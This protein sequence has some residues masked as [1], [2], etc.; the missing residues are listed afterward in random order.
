M[1]PKV[2]GFSHT[3]FTGGKKTGFLADALGRF[4]LQR[5]GVKLGVEA[6]ITDDAAKTVKN[7]GDMD[8]LGEALFL[9]QVRRWAEGRT[10]GPQVRFSPQVPVVE[11]EPYPRHLY[12][13][14]DLVSNALLRKET[15][16]LSATQALNEELGSEKSGFSSEYRAKAS[17][18]LSKLLNPDLS[19]YELEGLGRAV[20]FARSLKMYEVARKN[21]VTHMAL[22]DN[23]AHDLIHAFSLEGSTSLGTISD[24][25]ARRYQYVVHEKLL[26]T[27]EKFMDLESKRKSKKAI[28]RPSF[29]T[30]IR[31]YLDRESRTA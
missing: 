10:Y 3:V 23:H 26:R 7:A 18:F 29:R 1:K 4:P 15:P 19:W 30:L 28:P 31:Q 2:I 20:A 11:L 22:G 5:V 21:G 14:H 27:Y 16:N 12:F 9:R 6:V 24:A 8:A 17:R 13:L 25:A